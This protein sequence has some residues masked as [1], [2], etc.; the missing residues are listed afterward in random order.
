M[1]L[2]N[3]IEECWIIRWKRE[4]MM[5]SVG[6]K[7]KGVLKFETIVNCLTKTMIWQTK[8]YYTY[9]VTIIVHLTHYF[10]FEKKK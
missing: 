2:K 3:I 6:K 10:L 9:K 8:V 4:K 7:K 5:W 1:F